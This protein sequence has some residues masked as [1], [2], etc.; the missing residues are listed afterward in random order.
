MT[1][2]STSGASA[3]VGGTSAVLVTRTVAGRVAGVAKELLAPKNLPS[4]ATLV[5]IEVFGTMTA[6]LSVNVRVEGMLASVG[7]RM[8][9][10]VWLEIG[11]VVAN[12]STCVVT[13]SLV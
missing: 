11:C 8:V 3:V 12:T 5:C 13:A 9:P 4:L 6:V 7:F 1:T 2:A 10:A